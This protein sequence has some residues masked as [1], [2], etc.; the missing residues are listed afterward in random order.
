MNN[1]KSYSLDTVFVLNIHGFPPSSGINLVS[2]DMKL[3][4]LEILIDL[5]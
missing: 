3:T 4:K 2:N 1:I 5:F